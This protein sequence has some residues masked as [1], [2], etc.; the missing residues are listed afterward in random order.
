LVTSVF[1]KLF[2]ALPL[3]RMEML[4]DKM[5]DISFLGYFEGRN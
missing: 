4:Q 1:H 5:I 3:C 2:M